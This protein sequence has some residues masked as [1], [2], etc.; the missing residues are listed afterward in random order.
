VWER[1]SHPTTPLNTDMCKFESSQKEESRTQSVDSS[2]AYSKL[3]AFNFFEARAKRNKKT[4][5]GLL[6]SCSFKMLI[7]FRVSNFACLTCNRTS[8]QHWCHFLYLYRCMWGILLLPPSFTVQWRLE[9]FLMFILI[10]E[11]CIL[12]ALYTVVGFWRNI[13]GLWLKREQKHRP[14]KKRCNTK[15]S[16]C[17]ARN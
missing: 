11:G 10:L 6:W 13:W 12:T 14:T 8:T 2:K 15:P 7:H 16:D 4:K 17:Q 9:L 1:R 3:R 5:D